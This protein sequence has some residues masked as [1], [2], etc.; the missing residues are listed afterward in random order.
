MYARFGCLTVLPWILFAQM[1]WDMSAVPVVA[2]TSALYEVPPE[3]NDRGGV[4]D[5]QVKRGARE[6][7]RQFRYHY[8]VLIL[9]ETVDSLDGEPINDAALRRARPLGKDGIY[10][11]M[12]RQE[13]DAAVVVGLNKA[14][15]LL[16]GPD[17]ANIREAFLG[18]FRAGDANGG[19]EKGV[20]TIGTTL[21]NAS[22]T[23]PKSNARDVMFPAT[24]LFALLAVLV[25]LQMGTT[26]EDR[27]KRR[28]RT[29]LRPRETVLRGRHSCGP[30][31]ALGQLH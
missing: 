25:A 12:A 20:R 5:K 24:I 3:I 17:R 26:D 10:I 2:A 27:R 31:Q 11:L 21:A 18:P 22:A 28:Q 8:R 6:A 14:H 30:G 1:S 29:S 9:V 15:G 13:R 7:L 4:F 19:L 16:T 23:K